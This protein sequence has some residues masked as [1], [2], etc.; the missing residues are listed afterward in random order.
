MKP[1]TRTIEHTEYVPVTRDG[2]THIAPRTITVEQPLPPRDWDQIVLT[3]VTGIAIAVGAGCIAWST[4]AIG[5]LLATAAHPAIAYGGAA[6][7]DLLWM[8]CLAL[9]WLARYEPGKAKG[10]QIAGYIGLA[11]AVGALV[12]EGALADH[13]A[14]GIVGAAI[15]VGVKALWV[16]VLRHHAK[17]LDPDTQQWVDLE[18]AEVGGEL[19]LAAVRRRLARS[20]QQLA[21]HTAA[22]PHIGDDHGPTDAERAAEYARNVLGVDDDELTAQLEAAGLVISPVTSS[23]TSGP[24]DDHP[25]DRPHDHRHDRH[26]TTISA[27]FQRREV[28]TS[29]VDPPVTPPP[30]QMTGAQRL[31][32][33]RK[34]DREARKGK[35][36]RPVTIE[37]LQTELGLSRREATDLRAAILGKQVTR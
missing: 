22:Y 6:T 26:P 31:A 15:S 20:R 29:P 21:A 33:A 27:G 13:L 10:P 5:H 9:E 24:W 12:T 2:K 30:T 34:L 14:A 37:T 3:A 16:L 36:A 32:A 19:A 1:R 35:P 8:T 25:N 11:I 17:A 28:V 7:F 23:V 18:T 4:S